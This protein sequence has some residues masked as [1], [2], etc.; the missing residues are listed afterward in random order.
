MS[1]K[2][3]SFERGWSQ[4]KI[5]D[6]AKVRAKLMASL[7]LTTRAAFLNRKRGDVEPKVSEVK[8]I[9]AVFSEYGI[10]EVWGTCR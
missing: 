5:A 2:E 7:N 8:A 1:K 6:V 3:F 9:E 10:K 4:V